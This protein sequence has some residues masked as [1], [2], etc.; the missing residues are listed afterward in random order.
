MRGA[1]VNV[2][3]WSPLP[4]VTPPNNQQVCT[5]LLITVIQK[6][7]DERSFILKQPTQN[8]AN[9]NPTHA[10]ATTRTTL[11]YHCRYFRV[12]V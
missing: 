9:P 12:K 11:T 7:M 6:S 4:V 1:G 10:S 8:D 3:F 2:A 5:L